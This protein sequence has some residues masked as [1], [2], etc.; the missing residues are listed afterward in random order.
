LGGEEMR[1]RGRGKEEGEERRARRV[2][3]EVAMVEVEKL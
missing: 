3:A 2:Q 1:V